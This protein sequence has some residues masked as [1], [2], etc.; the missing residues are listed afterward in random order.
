MSDSDDPE[1]LAP[2]PLENRI[3]CKRKGCGH[4]LAAHN[5]AGLCV[6][7]DCRCKC[8]I[9]PYSNFLEAEELF[10]SKRL[11]RIE[12]TLKVNPS[13][14]MCRGTGMAPPISGNLV[15]PNAVTCPRCSARSRR[16]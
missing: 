14:K 7:A 1:R 13:C 9:K 11:P 12:S 16:N 2:V 5:G 15:P 10:A 3:E 6:A 4:S 8:Y